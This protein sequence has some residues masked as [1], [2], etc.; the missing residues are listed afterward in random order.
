M[1]GLLSAD[2]ADGNALPE[3]PTN[4][5]PLLRI[6]LLG[7]VLIAALAAIY[8]SPLKS[9]FAKPA[10]LHDLLAPLGMAMYPVCLLASGLLVAVGMPRLLLCGVGAAIFG[11]WPGLLI[12]QGGTLLGYYTL[13]L[14]VRWG[15]R[16]V[17]LHKWPKLRKW[18]DLVQD[19]GMLGVVLA[20]QV[21][22]HGTLV[23][24]CLGLTR[25]RHRDFLIGT[26]IGLFPEAIP[27]ALIGAGLRKDS[28]QGSI[29][30]ITIAV[31]AFAV[32]AM[33]LRY[34]LRKMRKD[35][36]GL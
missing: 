20:R 15:G 6:A 36:I 25:L 28:L 16:D 11:F 12:S 34:M 29:I 17:V 14:F 10:L 22:I 33:G 8:V 23:N 31:V 35:K 26:T 5:K 32:L 9:W 21:P 4:S 7:V 1:P 18:A 27:V 2:A 3:A 30:Y 19:Q 13:F 24:L